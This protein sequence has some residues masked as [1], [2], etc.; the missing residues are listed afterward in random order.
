MRGAHRGRGPFHGLSRQSQGRRLAID[1]PADHEGGGRRVVV[2]DSDWRTMLA[3][4]AFQEKP[5]GSPH[6][7]AWCRQT[8]PLSSLKSLRTILDLDRLHSGSTSGSAMPPTQ[9]APTGRRRQAHPR[10]P[11]HSHHRPSATEEGGNPVPSTSTGGSSCG[12]ENE[13]GPSRPRVAS[14]TSAPRRHDQRPSGGAGGA[15]PVRAYPARGLPG[16]PGQ[17]QDDAGA[18]ARR[19]ALASRDPGHP[20]RSQG[21]PL[22]LRPTRH[23]PARRARGAAGRARGPAPARGRGRPLHAEATRRPAAVHRGRARWARGLCRV[24]N[25]NR[26]PGSPRP[27][28]PG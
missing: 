25:G 14:P 18:G 11:C 8:R 13:G 5:R 6:F 19:A 7:L 24:T 4:A 27:P 2:E 28:S 15:R 21:G 3:F 1:R 12:G 10:S 9:P 26:P 22:L 20:G 23:G 17:R 16:G